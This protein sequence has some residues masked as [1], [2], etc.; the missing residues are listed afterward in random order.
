[1]RRKRR[2]CTSSSITRMRTGGVGSLLLSVVIGSLILECLRQIIRRQPY[3]NG[4]TAGTRPGKRVDAAAV[5]ADH[6][7]TDGQAQ[8]ATMPPGISAHGREEHIEDP[9][10]VL[11]RNAG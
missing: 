6:A 3:G 9:F 5:G 4:G 7:M 10:A 11:F 8:P 2:I 1:M